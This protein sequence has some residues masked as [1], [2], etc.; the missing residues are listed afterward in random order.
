MS[1]TDRQ[2]QFVDGQFVDTWNPGRTDATE[3]AVV[4]YD[5][6]DGLPWWAAILDVCG[7]AAHEHIGAALAAYLLYPVRLLSRVSRDVVVI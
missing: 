6:D 2:F 7:C 1:A 5:P 3:P 4:C